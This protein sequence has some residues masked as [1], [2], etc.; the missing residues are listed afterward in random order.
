MVICSTSGPACPGRMIGFPFL[1]FLLILVVRIQPV[2]GRCYYADGSVASGD[3]P[4]S[5]GGTSTCCGSGYACLSNRICM[6]TGDEAQKPGAS[7]YVRG[8][9]TD[10]SW[11]SASCPLYC[12][13]SNDLLSG[14]MGIAKCPNITLDEYYCIDSLA[15]TVNCSEQF[16]VFEFQGIEKSCPQ[17]YALR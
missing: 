1:L 2:V 10:R 14:G 3:T 16:G 15:N 8:S 12:I 13:G 17:S 5:L 4:C 9:C 7:L 6:A 11:R